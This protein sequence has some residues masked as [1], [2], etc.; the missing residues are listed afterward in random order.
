MEGERRK[1]GE[2]GEGTQSL[3]FVSRIISPSAWWS[4]MSPPSLQHTY[5]QEASH[6]STIKHVESTRDCARD[7]RLCRGEG[8]GRRGVGGGGRCEV[9]LRFG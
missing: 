6:A 4:H 9:W 3:I 5:Y 7:A 2:E 1:G 8:G